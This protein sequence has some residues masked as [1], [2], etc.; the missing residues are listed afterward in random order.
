MGNDYVL[1]LVQHALD[2]I[3]DRPI[4]VSAR[5]AARI[6]SL[7]GETEFAVYL[8]ME[9]KPTGGHPPANAEDTRR[10]MEDPSLWGNPDGPA[11]GAM[12]R[13]LAS[14]T[15]PSGLQTGMMAAHGLGNVESLIQMFPEDVPNYDAAFSRQLMRDVKE[16]VKHSVFVALCAWERQLTYAN[17]NERIFE[18]FRS[19]VDAMLAQGAPALLDQFSA[20][21]RRLRAATNDPAAPVAEELSQAITTCRRILK[22]VADHV[23]PGVPGA[24]TD[25]GHALNDAAYRNRVHEYVKTH[26]S[27][28]TTAETVNAAVGG[29]I[30]RFNAIDKLANKGVHAE[31]GVPEAELCAIHT[32]LVAGEL[33]ALG[34]ATP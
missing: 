5:R 34:E 24:K 30:E 8:G 13:Y 20:V 31:V 29:L 22:A 28:D 27:S 14:R 9:L 21:Y 10:L 7:L 25:A 11:E 15:I 2:E 26:T 12:T 4:D 1:T 23:L 3:D 32:Y 18:R 19:Q 17:V 16:R 6:A 33:L